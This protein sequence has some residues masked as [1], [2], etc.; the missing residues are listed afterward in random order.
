MTYSSTID[1]LI[2]AQ[3]TAFHGDFH[4]VNENQTSVCNKSWKPHHPGLLFLLNLLSQET[5]ERVLCTLLPRP[6]PGAFC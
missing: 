6:N 2:S 1:Q 4:F 5:E 3:H